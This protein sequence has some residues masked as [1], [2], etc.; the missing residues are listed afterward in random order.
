MLEFLFNKV[1]GQ[2][3]C[4]SIKNRIQRRCLPVNIAKFWRTPILKKFCEGLLLSLDLFSSLCI[5][6]LCV[7]LST[8]LFCYIE[9]YL[10]KFIED[11]IEDYWSLPIENYLNKKKTNLHVS[12]RFQNE[13]S[14]RLLSGSIDKLC[15]N[16]YG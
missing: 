15:F 13:P 2:K 16:W 4:N 12:V 11:Y 5:V 6:S 9:D 10:L 3:T 7:L 14:N 1:A 8:K